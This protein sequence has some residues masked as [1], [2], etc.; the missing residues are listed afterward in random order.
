[1]ANDFGEKKLSDQIKM[2]AKHKIPYL[3][4]IGENEEKTQTMSVRSLDSGEEVQLEKSTLV[5]YF[6]ANKPTV[7]AS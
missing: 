5:E 6:T 4:V 7:A 1:M 3:I 2:A